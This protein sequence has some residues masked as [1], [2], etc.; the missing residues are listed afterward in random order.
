MGGDTTTI[1]SP[2]P[3]VAPAAGETTREAI[4]AQTE[5]LPDILAAQQEFGPQFT[6]QQL[7]QL[8]QF[9]PEFTEQLLGLQ[10]KFGPRVGEALRAEQEATQPELGAAREELTGFLGEAGGVSPEEAAL[11]GPESGAA[12]QTGIE[13]LRQISAGE[14][15]A[16]TPDFSGAGRAALEEFVG[17]EGG[18]SPRE[19]SALQQDIRGAQGVRGFGLVSGAG[20]EAEA[21]IISEQRRARELQRQQVAGQLAQFET[22]EAQFGAGLQEAALGRRAQAAQVAT[23]L[24]DELKQLL[25]LQRGLQTQRLNIALS[26]AGRAPVQGISQTQQQPGAGGPGQLV[27]NVTPGQIF[28]LASGN[29][30]TQAGIFG[31]QAGLA[32][33]QAQLNA[34]GSPFGQILGQVGGGLL[35]SVT[36][37]FGSS[38]GSSFGSSL[39]N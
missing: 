10:E 27:Q 29:F 33:Q 38:V 17:Q 22:G 19:L 35:G 37:G 25:E 21:S 14:E 5:S 30:G 39:F 15:G 34:Q 3:P 11:F 24:P 36:G 31:T 32:S 12:R 9:G 23:T 28:G 13:R 8:Q 2:A 7:E 18:F 20:A 26:T 16:I 1:Q 4:Q 6:Q